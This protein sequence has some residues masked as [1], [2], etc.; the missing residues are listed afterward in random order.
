M[1]HS[2]SLYFAPRHEVEDPW[3]GAHTAG[4]TK[5]IANI[6]GP[7]A[8]G[9]VVGL[10]EQAAMWTLYTTGREG[11]AIQTT[12]ARI[13]SVFQGESRA[14]NIARV[15]Y[16]DYEKEEDC[17]SVGISRP[18]NVLEPFLCKRRGFEHE[19]EARVLIAFPDQPEVERVASQLQPRL[20]QTFLSPPR[21]AL[22]VFRSR[23]I[24]RP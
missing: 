10:F 7:S 15:K 13:K 14:I 21:A 3:E 20:G 1:L 6:F 4:L 5:R 22:P 16:L 18:F 23:S 24:S 9:D 17:P 12:V 11:V 19:R 8:S 2:R